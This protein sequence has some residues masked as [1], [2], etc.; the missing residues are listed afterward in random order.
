MG[1]KIAIEGE[2]RKR[3]ESEKG[4]EGKRRAT[5]RGP[6]FSHAAPV[7]VHILEICLNA[8]SAQRSLYLECVSV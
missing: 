5:E 3:E 4:E 1:E 2:G 7:L 8:F 6:N